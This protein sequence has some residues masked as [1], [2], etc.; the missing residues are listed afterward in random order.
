MQ[1]QPNNQGQM[2]QL[3]LEFIKDIHALQSDT[4]M[5]QVDIGVEHYLTQKF[6][7][8]TEEEKVNYSGSIQVLSQTHY[9]TKEEAKYHE[10]KQFNE[11]ALDRSV[12]TRQQFDHMITKLAGAI[13]SQDFAIQT[14]VSELKDCYLQHEAFADNYTSIEEE[15]RAID[16][17][18]L[19]VG[20]E[21]DENRIQTLAD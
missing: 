5:A 4:Q 1:A 19:L 10:F 7:E 12:K 11:S 8:A 15:L 6:L 3:Q 16:E 13:E 14:A 18:M 17:Q 20:A 9:L 2:P 21:A